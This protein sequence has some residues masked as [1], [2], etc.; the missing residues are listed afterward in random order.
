MQLGTIIDHKQSL[1]AYT[2]AGFAFPSIPSGK[3]TIWHHFETAEGDHAVIINQRGQAPIA[4]D[5]EQEVNGCSLLV[6]IDPPD[7]VT[8]R[9]TLERAVRELLELP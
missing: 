1:A 9:A 8:A 4:S 5:D 3:N 6:A 2:A 7:A